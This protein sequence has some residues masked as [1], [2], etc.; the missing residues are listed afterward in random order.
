MSR[1]YEI[2]TH[3]HVE[4]ALIAGLTP[5]QLLRLVAG[6]SIAYALWDQLTFLPV[7]VRTALTSV[8]ALRG[9]VFALSSLAT[10]LWISGC[11]PQHCF[12]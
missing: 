1:V 8:A 12:S 9:V 6:A 7:A 3:L 2:P 5:H 10:D 4:D 11:S